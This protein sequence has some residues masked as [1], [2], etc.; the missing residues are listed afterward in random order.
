MDEILRQRLWR[1]IEALPEAQVYQVLDYIE[2]LGSRYA[3]TP[4]RAPAT[5]FQKFGERLQDRMRAQGVA[6]SAMRG[7][8]DAFGAAD[9]VLSGVAEAGRTLLREVEGGLRAP[10]PRP[11]DP[12]TPPPL[13]TAKLA[14]QTPLPLP[15][16]AP[17][18]RRPDE[19]TSPEA[20]GG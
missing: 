3:R 10:A 15:E 16:A 19:P 12:A 4:V 7:T 5:G 18:A 1:H 11:G 2:F 8:L 9:R 14:P 13:S 17:A 6:M 20:P